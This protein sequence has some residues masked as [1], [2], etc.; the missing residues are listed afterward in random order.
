MRFG[1]REK[2]AELRQID[3]RRQVARVYRELGLTSR[4]LNLVRAAGRLNV[5]VVIDSRIGTDGEIGTNSKGQRVIVLSESPC[6]PRPRFTLAHEIAHELLRLNMLRP[7]SCRSPLPAGPPEE[8]FCDFVAGLLLM[9]LPLF[10]GRVVELANCYPQISVASY[11]RLAASFVV[12]L[13]A[14]LLQITLLR[15]VRFM[16][17]GM[18]AGGQVNS[19]MRSIRA[20]SD[21]WDFPRR[22][23]SAEA[24]GSLPFQNYA[25][26]DG[27]GSVSW[28]DGRSVTTIPLD[29][30]L[31]D[32]SV[33]WGAD[34]GVVL[35]ERDSVRSAWQCRHFLRP[36]RIAYSHYQH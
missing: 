13:K 8:S 2:A 26:G 9:P 12:S 23:H 20:Y 5:Q 11:E 1:I 24:S 31:R 27:E 14:F 19:A 29:L 36:A 6:N 35:T 18:D 34:G 3:F 16:F 32:S 30:N 7:V 22:L 15:S 10:H 21:G 17:E 28:R 25:I 33:D 4:G